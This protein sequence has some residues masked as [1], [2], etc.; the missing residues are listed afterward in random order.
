MRVINGPI[1]ETQTYKSRKQLHQLDVVQPMAP[2]IPQNL[3]LSSSNRR[4]DQLILEQSIK[5]QLQHTTPDTH[6]RIV[7]SPKSQS[8]VSQPVRCQQ[9][10]LPLKLLELWSTTQVLEVHPAAMVALRPS[11]K[12]KKR[13]P[14]SFSHTSSSTW[15]VTRRVELSRFE[16]RIS[17]VWRLSTCITWT[18][19]SSIAPAISKR[20]T[21]R[22]TST[23]W[24]KISGRTDTQPN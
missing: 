23:S 13:R 14:P 15:F 21:W 16:R 10:A 11:S 17:Q 4:D 24:L 9:G 22:P 8:A 12:E 1:S 7:S 3:P 2:Q 19:G 5:T 6:L 18:S 20:V